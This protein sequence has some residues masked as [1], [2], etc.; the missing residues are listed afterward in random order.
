MISYLF[1]YFYTHLTRSAL[2]HPGQCFM[3]MTTMN[4]IKAAKAANPNS[5]QTTLRGSAQNTCGCSVVVV[6]VVVVCYK[7]AN[8]SDD[9]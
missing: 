4:T 3:E 6:D 5:S 2:E 8:D 7:T 9:D 1:G